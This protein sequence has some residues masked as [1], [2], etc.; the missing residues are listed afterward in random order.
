MTLP[1]TGPVTSGLP[2][3]DA[4]EQRTHDAAA[5][6]R[7]RRLEP[8][9]RPTAYSTEIAERILDGLAHG[10]TMLDICDDEGMPTSR[11]VHSW[12]TED[13]EGFRTHYHLARETGCHRLADEILAIADDS[14]NDWV[15]RRIQAGRPDGSV[16]AIFFDH[17][18]ARRS[19]MRIDARRWLLSKMLPRIYGDRPDPNARPAGT[20]TLAE[21]LREIDGRTRGLPKDDIRM[22]PNQADTE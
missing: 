9:G 2:S 21:L 6:S 4:G 12:V 3:T 1:I 20:D 8:R 17:E 14:R 18:H 19:Q 11:T 16:E 10:R 15:R 22:R 7:Y 13:R 5:A